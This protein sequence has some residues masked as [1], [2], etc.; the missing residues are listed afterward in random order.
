[1]PLPSSQCVLV[2]HQFCLQWFSPCLKCTTYPP[3]HCNS[4]TFIFSSFSCFSLPLLSTG[5]LLKH[6]LCLQLFCFYKLA[7]LNNK[8]INLKIKEGGGNTHI[9]S[10][11]LVRALWHKCHSFPLQQPLAAIPSSRQPSWPSYRI[12]STSRWPLFFGFYWVLGGFF[13]CLFGFFSWCGLQCDLFWFVVFGVV[14]VGFFWFNN[15][16]NKEGLQPK[17]ISCNYT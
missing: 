12:C 1:M 14:L 10:Q 4:S 15:K 17:L 7:L 2:S 8:M 9:N 6:T 13:I 5:N 16:T 3:W 11:P